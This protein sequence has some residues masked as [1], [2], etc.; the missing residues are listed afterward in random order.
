[1]LKWQWILAVLIMSSVGGEMMVSA[2]TRTRY[3]QSSGVIVCW[4]YIFHDERRDTM[5]KITT[6]AGYFRFIAPNKT[7]SVKQDPNMTVRNRSISI[8]FE[9]SEIIFHATAIITERWSIC[10]AVATDVET[11]V[12]YS[13]TD[14]TGD[15]GYVT[16]VR[17]I[18]SHDVVKV[19]SP[20][21]ASVSIPSYGS[22]KYGSADFHRI[23]HGIRDWRDGGSGLSGESLNI[24]EPQGLTKPE[25]R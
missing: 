7:F 9:D 11:G 3:I 24:S 4:E 1:L 5:L 23:Q 6:D 19:I 15:A 20:A 2:G 10:I 13:L 14:L 17:I 12:R 21:N 16:G 18:P 22:I 25:P 8:N